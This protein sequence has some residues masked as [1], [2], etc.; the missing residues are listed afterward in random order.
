MDNQKAIAIHV[1]NG[2]EQLMAVAK[3]E[4]FI[5]A[6]T[7]QDAV[8]EMETTID[9]LNEGPTVIEAKDLTDAKIGEVMDQL[10]KA[11]GHRQAVND[12]LYMGR[13]VRREA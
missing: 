9:Y 7:I 3:K 13:L 4:G 2:L 10:Y 8:H 5:A 6:D 12:H 1:L 11:A